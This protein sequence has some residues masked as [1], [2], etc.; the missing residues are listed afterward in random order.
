MS[1]RHAPTFISLFSGIGGLD[2]GLERAGWRCV[3]QVEIDPFCRRVLAKHWPDVPKFEDVRT[4]QGTEINEPIDLIAGGFPCQDISNAQASNG[5][6]R[7][8]LDGAR[9][10]MWREFSRIIRAVRPRLCLVENVAAL[11]GLHFGRVLADLAESGFDAWWD[12]LPAA[13]VG[14]RIFRD[15]V[16]IVASSDPLLFPDGFTPW[17][18]RSASEEKNR[19]ESFS[20]IRPS[21]AGTPWAAEP[22]VDRVAYGVPDG[23]HRNRGL[24]NAVVP[25]VAEWIGRRIIESLTPEA[26]TL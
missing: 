17:H 11:L 6:G 10:G 5:R 12:C 14:A 8:G 7:T 9:S 24:G 26:P 18:V 16:F 19:W 20:R 22:G 15:R 13:A 1:G 21:F 3:A 25:Q 2:L 23:I 4:F